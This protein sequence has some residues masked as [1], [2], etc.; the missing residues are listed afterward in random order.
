ARQF[1]VPWLGGEGAKAAT[2]TFLW[3]NFIADWPLLNNPNPNAFTAPKMYMKSWPWPTINTIILLTS[4]IT[5]TIA[6]H[7]LIGA[8][9]ARL[10]KFL[11]CTVILG[12]SFV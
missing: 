10:N 6:H 7:A 4:S 11:A 12:L 1:S 5:V 2:H 8:N 3:P 9:R